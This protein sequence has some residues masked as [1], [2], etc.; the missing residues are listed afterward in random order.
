MKSIS[1][2][3][4]K[5]E[6][7]QPMQDKVTSNFYCREL[8]PN[9]VSLTGDLAQG[10]GSKQCAYGSSCMFNFHRYAD[11]IIIVPYRGKP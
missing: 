9:T 6:K 2:T 8:A 7:P 3:S 10:D 11:A 1:V 5:W 4:I